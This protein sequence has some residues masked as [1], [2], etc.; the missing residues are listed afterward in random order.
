MFPDPLSVLLDDQNDMYDR[1]ERD[2]QFLG[3][4]KRDPDMTWLHPDWP[5]AEYSDEDVLYWIDGEDDEYG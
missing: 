4:L 3:R 1:H 5:D 2:K